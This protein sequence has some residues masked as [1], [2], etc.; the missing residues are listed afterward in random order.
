MD[1]FQ[2]FFKTNIRD[3]HYKGLD[4]KYD[5]ITRTFS[6]SNQKVGKKVQKFMQIKAIY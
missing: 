3:L 4:T 2:T 6:T 5:P 1:V